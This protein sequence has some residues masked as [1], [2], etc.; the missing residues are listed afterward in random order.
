MQNGIIRL[1]RVCFAGPAIG[2]LIAFASPATAQWAPPWGQR[3]PARSSEASRRKDTCWPRRLCGGQESTL[4]MSAL[5]P[6]GIDASSLTREA[7]RSLRASRLQEASADPC[8]PI[9][10]KDLVGLNQVSDR[11]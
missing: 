1:L 5:A 9:A 4:P 11:R 3:G 8:S 10:T 6:G 7:V 2:G